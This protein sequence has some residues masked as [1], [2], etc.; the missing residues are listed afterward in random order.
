MSTR[1]DVNPSRMEDQASAASD[2]ADIL[3][4]SLSVKFELSELLSFDVCFRSDISRN[5]TSKVR[6]AHNTFEAL[7]TEPNIKLR[8][9]FSINI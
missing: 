9:A 2:L 5:G 1:I 3:R 4:F 7:R 6:A 8:K